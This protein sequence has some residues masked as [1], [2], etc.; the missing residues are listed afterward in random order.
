M[1]QSNPHFRHPGRAS[2]ELGKLMRSLPEHLYGELTADQQLEVEAAGKHADNA[3]GTLLHGL[4]SLGRVLWAAG[5]NTEFPADPDDCASVGA[6]VTEIALQ[7]QLL[8]E[9][10]TSVAEHELR[11]AQK[12]QSKESRT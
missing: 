12:G 10:R 4:Q 3:T 2:Y 8:D 7:L 1:S 9:F 6:L 5:A 11:I